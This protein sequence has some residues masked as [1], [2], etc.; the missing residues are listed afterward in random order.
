[1][2]T[3]CAPVV[4]FA[5]N[6]PVH[7]R[8]ALDSLAAA[9]LSSSSMV[10]V[11]SDG[12]RNEKAAAGVRAV[13]SLLREPG[14]NACFDIFSVVEAD[15]NKGLATSVIEG[16]TGILAEH[17]SVI[18]LED[19]LLV[20]KD[21]LSFMNDCLVFFRNEAQ[22][23]SVTG[24]CPITRIPAGYPHDVMAV[25]RNCSQGW[26]TWR[27]RWS[28]VDWSASGANL[29]RR[30]RALRKVFVSAGSDRMDRLRRQVSGQLDTWSIRFG[31]WQVLSGRHTIYP[32]CNRVRNIGFDGSGMHSRAGEEKNAFLETDA[33]PYRL[34]CPGV[35]PGILAEFHRAYSGSLLARI[36]RG[37][38]NL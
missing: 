4:V 2:T 9:D 17:E 6:R 21:F 28:E 30:D 10:R 23:G 15:Y 35:S 32:V 38:R 16:I 14:W 25:P 20:A 12:P 34:T 27:D 24:H 22:V 1:M 8:R 33:T 26:A 3:R 19:D 31:L 5:Y 37:L 18:V 7:L 11:F 13:R 36:K 29:I